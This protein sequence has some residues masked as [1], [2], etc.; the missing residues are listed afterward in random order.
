MLYLA[1]DRQLQAGEAK[2]SRDEDAVRTWSSSSTT[3]QQKAR[4]SAFYGPG[5]V[6]RP[7][8]A[9]TEAL[10]RAYRAAINDELYPG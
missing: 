4:I 7:I 5:K 1:G 10:T 3:T 2:G 9:A 6:P 8:S